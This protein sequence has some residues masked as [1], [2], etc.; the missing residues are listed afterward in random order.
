MAG[1]AEFRRV[2]KIVHHCFGVPL[3]MPQNH[4]EG[5][6]A[7][8]ALTVLVHDHCGHAHLDAGVTVGRVQTDDRMTSRASEPV[9]V[10]LSTINL[11]VLSQ[12]SAE[13]PNR[14]VATIAMAGE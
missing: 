10:N 1:S 9:G 14:V 4:G 13:N 8:D 6:L 2:Q 7:R 5:N 3:R 11:R 12:C